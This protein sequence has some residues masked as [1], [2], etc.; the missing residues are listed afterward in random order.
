MFRKKV[1]ILI[2]FS[3]ALTFAVGYFSRVTT[4]SHYLSY[5]FEDGFQVTLNDRDLGVCKDS[6]LRHFISEKLHEGDV[7]SVTATLPDRGEIAAPA[8]Y[9]RSSFCAFELLVD[10]ELFKSYSMGDLSDHKFIGEDVHII[11][12]P[13]D[14]IGRSITIRIY[15]TSFGVTSLIRDYTF[16]DYEDL[17]HRFI[18]RYFGALNAGSV[19]FLLGLIL[20]LISTI[21][22]IARVENMQTHMAIS[23]IFI[24]LGLLLHN[25]YGLVF[26][27]GDSSESSTMFYTVLMVSLPLILQYNRTIYKNAKSKLIL[28][29][30]ITCDLYC[31]VRILLH[32]TGVLYYNQ[33]FPLFIIPIIL[34]CFVMHRSYFAQRD[35]GLLDETKKI[36]YTGLFL[37]IFF[38]VIAWI[39]IKLS[40]I[41]PDPYAYRMDLLSTHVF[42]NSVMFVLFSNVIVFLWTS[43]ASFNQDEQYDV[44]T[45]VAYEDVLTGLSNRASLD[46]SLDHLQSEV[47]D[48]CIISLDINYL[49]K[50]N[51]TYGHT[52]GDLLLKN[53]ASALKETFKNETACGRTGGDEFVVLSRSTDPVKISRMLSE[54]D[55]RLAVLTQSDEDPLKYRVAY[56]YAFRHEKDSAHNVYLLA[57][58][59]MYE[60][61]A[62]IKAHR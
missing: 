62:K 32:A 5:N 55:E 39:M 13:K 44:L 51:D 56:G 60:H 30:E 9:F 11:S 53:F 16:G 17:E 47:S 43:A 19:S 61:K 8:I 42:S 36:Q 24:A 59:R 46:R 58:Q 37:G 26:L 10:D 33:L 48:Y 6:H 12:L 20:L 35:A 41:L 49:K 34:C 1:L 21:F 28:I 57:D 3:F 52:Y 50:T 40:M 14:Y 22:S 45:R 7:I 23:L 38:I 18:H 29:P 25:Y 2:I 4:Q 15:P 54:L 31:F 27:Y